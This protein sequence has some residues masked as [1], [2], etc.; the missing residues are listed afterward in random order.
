[1]PEAVGRHTEKAGESMSHVEESE[2]KFYD[3][4]WQRTEVNLIGGQLQI[5]GVRSIR[6][7]KILICSC[8]SGIEPVLAANAGADVY[9]FDISSTAVEKALAVAQANG[10]SVKADVMDFNSLKYPDDFFDF[11]YGSLILHHIDCEKS[12]GHI[13][14]C[15][16]ANGIA[17]FWENSD[18]NPILRFARRMMFGQPGGYQKRQFLVFSRQGTTDEYPLTEEEVNILSGI[19]GGHIERIY[20][21]FVF[22][23]LLS[24]FGW[25]NKAFLKL[26]RAVD[27]LIARLCP[28]AMQYSF[29]QGIWLQKVEESRSARQD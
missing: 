25:R 9:A 3:E 20:T 18:R 15:L 4:Y 27:D 14:R 29:A 2:R 21:Q 26:L 19:F 16:K 10:A 6:G 13:Y 24:G 17:F 23:Q 22:L 28:M 11:M 5:P 8:G 7:A 1:L 12:G